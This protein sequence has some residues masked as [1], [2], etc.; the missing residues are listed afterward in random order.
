MR[1]CGGRQACG[2]GSKAFTLIEVLVV[3]GIIGILV[4]MLLPAIQS[5]RE[6]ARRTSCGNNLKQIGLALSHYMSAAER[7]PPG[8]AATAWQSVTP[9]SNQFFEWTTFLHTLLPQLDEVAYYEALRGPLFRVEFITTLPAIDG[10]TLPSLL[11]P[12][13]M[14]T[15]GLWRSRNTAF[16]SGIGAAGVRLA[17]SNY[18]GIFSGTSVADG[19]ATSPPVPNQAIPPLPA[20]RRAVFGYGVGTTPQSIKDGASNTLA[21][22]EYLKGTSDTDGRGAFW[23]NDAGMQMLHARHGPNSSQPDVLHR[24]RITSASQ[25]PLDWGCSNLTS[26][27]RGTPT[28]QPAINLPCVAG[29]VT[30]PF[31][32]DDF[33]S[34]RS[35]HRGGV[36]AVFC[37]GRVQFIADT[38]ESQSA[39][40]TPATP[41]GVWQRLAWIDDGLTVELP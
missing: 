9:G 17:K 35:R 25:L 4:A 26:G 38:I 24:R 14:Q 5:A 3:I 15:L 27:G 2:D 18:L 32:A 10:I 37:D 36:N 33:A 8:V 16:S 28:N 1:V 39:V 13:D 21:V 7:L 30:N 11:C 41:Y 23:Y 29:T 19:I 34:A 20:A 6:S 31:G 40:N 22:C 12:S